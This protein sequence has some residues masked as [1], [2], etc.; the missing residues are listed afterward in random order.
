M[1]Y[2]LGTNST[3]YIFPFDDILAPGSTPV[4]DTNGLIFELSGTGYT[5][6]IAIYSGTAE[7]PATP[8]TTSSDCVY[9]WGEYLTSPESEAGL[10]PGIPIAVNNAGFGDPL[11]DFILT[12]EPSSLLLFGT[13]ILGFAAF[14]Y[15]RWQTGQHWAA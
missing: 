6:A 12:P 9:W 15:R 2:P 10:Y 7:N 13:G 1:Y 11:D 14:M 3:N 5:A 4:V 8:C